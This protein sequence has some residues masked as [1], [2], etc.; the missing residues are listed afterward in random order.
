MPIAIRHWADTPPML[1]PLPGLTVCRETN[2]SFMAE[3]QARSET[4]IAKRF[5]EGH[6]AYVA[7]RHDEPAAWGWAATTTAHI[8]ELDATFDIPRADRYLWNF[9]TLANHRG[10]GIYPRLLDAIVTAESDASRYW[11]GYAPENHASGAGIRK[12]GFTDIAALSFDRAGRPAVRDII[13]GGAYAAARFLGLPVV[14]DVLATCWRC[15]RAA[16]PNPSKCHGGP[17]R[18]DYQRPAACEPSTAA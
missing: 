9:V 3:L 10:H 7:W 15:A 11:V 14:D 2:V 16:A 5:F 1:E 12:A 4:E 17:C 18:C 6:R 13:D 8:G